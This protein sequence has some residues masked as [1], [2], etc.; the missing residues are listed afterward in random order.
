MGKRTEQ[1]FFKGRSTNAA[2]YVK[3][4]STSLAIKKN[5]SQNHVKI[6]SHS[7]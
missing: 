7:C 5:T 1:T 6:P 2:M 3:K 4:C